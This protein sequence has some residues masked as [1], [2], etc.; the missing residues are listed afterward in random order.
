MSWIK[1]IFSGKGD[2]DNSMPMEKQI[3]ADTWAEPLVETN[4]VRVALESE[5]RVTRVGDKF[6][7]HEETS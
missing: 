6:L 1:N 4:E 5:G 2:E 3:D 7:L